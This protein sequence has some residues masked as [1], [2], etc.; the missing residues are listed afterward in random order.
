HDTAGG[1]HVRTAAQEL[2]AVEPVVLRFRIGVLIGQVDH[3]DVVAGGGRRQELPPV[4]VM[5][6]DTSGATFGLGQLLGGVAVRQVLGTCPHRLGVD[7]DVVH[8]LGAVGDG[9][10]AS[11][12]LAG[13]D[14]QDTFHR[15]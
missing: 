2:L 5:D 7:V 12:P 1:Q 4:A 13:A 9:E 15:V 14:D 3:H 8:Q 6:P 11:H 10:L